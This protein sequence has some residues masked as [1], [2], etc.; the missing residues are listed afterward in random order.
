[1]RDHRVHTPLPSH[2]AL[3]DIP[4]RN[5][6]TPSLG[7]STLR[8]RHVCFSQRCID[9]ALLNV[10]ITAPASPPS[11]CFVIRVPLPSFLGEKKK[12]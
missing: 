10:A 5:R 6:E 8:R 2:F 4:A 1:M 9:Q 11:G 7:D 12:D 3:G